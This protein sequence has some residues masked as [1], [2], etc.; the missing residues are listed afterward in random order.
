MTQ[1]L[2]LSTI[3][4]IL[5]FSTGCERL[6]NVPAGEAFLRRHDIIVNA[7]PEEF[8]VSRDELLLFTKPKTNRRVMWFRF[9]HTV[10]LTVNKEKLR[11]SEQRTKEKCARKNEKRRA[12]GKPE[13]QCKSWRMFWAY[14][15]GEPTV[16]MDS[17]KMKKGAEQIHV[18]LKKKGFFHNRVE[19]LV[20]YN[21]KKTKCRIEY[22]VYPGQPSRVRKIQYKILDPEMAL[23]ERLIRENSL[24]D[25]MDV[26][27]T[28]KFDAERE[29]IANFYNDK[30]YYEFNKEYIVFK[31]DS[32]VGKDL[33]DITMIL[34]LQKESLQ[35]FPDSIAEVPHKKYFIGDIYVNTNYDMTHPDAVPTD[36]L[37]HDGYRILSYGDPEINEYVI[38][39]LQAYS[40]GDLYQKS[41][42]DKTYRR[43]SQLGVFRASTI[44]LVPRSVPVGKNIYI[45]DTYV[46]LTP[47]KKQS[48]TIDPHFTNRS[49]NMGIYGNMTYTHRNLFRGAE[50]MDVRI[51][52]GMEASQTLVQT[53]SPTDDAGQQIKRSFKLNTFEFGPEITYRVPRLWPFG[54]DFTSQSS[55]PQ[56]AVSAALNYQRR[57]D[58]E[59]TLSQIRFT[60]NWI[61]NPDVVRR[62]NLDVI[63][64]SIIKI[65]KSEGFQDFLN[66]LNDAFL[67]N[68]YQNHLVLATNLGYTWNTQ[69]AKYQRHYYYL[70]LGASGAG[71]MLNGAL[72]LADVKT[73]STGYYNIEGIRFA[74]YFRG[75][76]DFRY[77]WNVNEKNSFVWRA[78]GGMGV[79]RKNAITL[80]FEKSFFSG[81]SNGVRAWQAR[82]LGPGSYRNPDDPQTFNNIG[83][84]KLEGNLEYRF[85]LTKMFNWAFFVDAGNIWLIDEDQ[86]R[87]GADFTADRFMSEIAIG[88][89]L[90]VRLD[91]DFFLVRIDGGL[92]LKDPAKAQGER[93]LWQPK[94][95]Y[96]MYLA[97][98]GNAQSR[99]PLRS[100]LVFN[101]GIG[102][103]F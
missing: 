76:T 30:G 37:N 33:V 4:F 70:R 12:K 58:Y 16:L 49:G 98:T 22:L 81:G 2:L 100:N 40:P 99:I 102:F 92:Q 25:S 63:E 86:L 67:A 47:A 53:T 60:Y 65:Q 38:S 10:Y 36:T 6:R 42:L 91:F 24:I 55:E 103:P 20:I 27:D 3:V 90:G 62:V 97:S 41:M 14:T 45:L 66:S 83:E 21:D 7:P 28:E 11:I 52:A 9:N 73:D 32:S 44:Q 84:I 61:E 48:F 87:P 46:R 64:F 34:Q 78:Y 74:Q 15:V 71:N 82:T 80:P 26:F 35:E 59:R 88:G 101:L 23:S 19:P 29:R 43:Y 85:K 94:D 93:W 72:R 79:P 17:S 68:S 51:I 57:P 54:C 5:L 75:E 96:L 8:D 77:Y 50:A 1:R 31:A 39:C 89:G 18:F 95:E 56:S 13:K 69:K